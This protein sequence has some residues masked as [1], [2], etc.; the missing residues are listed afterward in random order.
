MRRA[1][2]R[3][4]L[5]KIQDGRG[6]DG[7]SNTVP[8]GSSLLVRSRTCGPDRA[9]TSKRPGT[10]SSSSHVSLASGWRRGVAQARNMRRL[11]R[12]HGRTG[13]HLK[14][15]DMPRAETAKIGHLVAVPR[16]RAVRRWRWRWRA[17]PRGVSGEWG[18]L[19]RAG[20][21]LRPGCCPVSQQ[22]S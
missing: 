5:A 22:A 13:L 14:D 7:I 2:Q 17:P 11:L 1:S 3:G 18:L 6:L 16:A 8:L 15:R 12:R 9:W 20:Y 10:R 21:G 4:V 19:P